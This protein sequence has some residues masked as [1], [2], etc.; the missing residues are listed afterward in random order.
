MTDLAR[1]VLIQSASLLQEFA[2]RLAAGIANLGLSAQPPIAVPIQPMPLSTGWG[3]ASAVALQLASQ[4]D[5]SAVELAQQIIGSADYGVQAS[6][7]IDC[8]LT[9]A[10]IADW[11]QKVSQRPPQLLTSQPLVANENPG[12]SNALSP[13]LIFKL[14]YAHARCCSLLRLADRDQ[15]LQLSEPNPLNS[16]RLWQI[17]A[18][19]AMPWLTSSGHLRLVHPQ[20]KLLL[21]QLLEFPGWLAGSVRYSS[22]AASYNQTV[23]LIP[24]PPAPKAVERQ[25]QLLCDRFEG[26]YR[27]CRIWGEVKEN[28]ELAIARLG[29]VAATHAVIQFWLRDLLGLDFPLEL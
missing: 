29:L 15:L 27:H 9:E 20:E 28:S 17:V 1:Y 14:Q 3:Y 8:R 6:G 5:Y 4:S 25:I 21:Q 2:D 10:A 22:I 16:P 19:A 12:L 24:W 7:W 23:I 18:P 11:L 26:F 13:E